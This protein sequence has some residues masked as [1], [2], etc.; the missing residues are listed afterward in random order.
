M[1]CLQCVLKDTLHQMLPIG[2]SDLLLRCC[3]HGGPLCLSGRRESS[4][5]SR[6]GEGRSCGR[7]WHML[8]RASKER[9]ARRSI[10]SHGPRARLQGRSIVCQRVPGSC[11]GTP[12][13]RKGLSRR[14]SHTKAG[15]P[16]GRTWQHSMKSRRAS[17]PAICRSGILAA[18]MRMIEASNSACRLADCSVRGVPDRL[19]PSQRRRALASL[20]SPSAFGPPPVPNCMSAVCVCIC[21]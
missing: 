4:P 13:R 19:P 20:G 14:E 12:E 1:V 10:P 6:G 3:P 5:P 15:R 7:Q 17:R 9:R 11:G 2:H 8:P 18:T 21:G 16:G